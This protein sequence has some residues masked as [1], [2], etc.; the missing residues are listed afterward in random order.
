MAVSQHNVLNKEYAQD[1]PKRAMWN[2]VNKDNGLS[3]HNG[4]L[5]NQYH[6]SCASSHIHLDKGNHTMCM[7]I[8]NIDID[9]T[10]IGCD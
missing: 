7:R 3:P 4:I 10:Q 1:W 8:R 5:S 9:G 2:K 6:L